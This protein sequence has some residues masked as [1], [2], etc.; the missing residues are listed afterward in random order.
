VIAVSGGGSGAMSTLLTEPGASGSVIE[1]LIPYSSS[2]MENFL[3]LVPEQACSERNAR[4]MAMAAYLR[5]VKLATSDCNRSI[6]G[7]ACTAALVT[8]RPRRGLH[9]IHVALQTEKM[10]R[11]LSLNLKKGARTREQEEALASDLII[12]AM[13]DLCEISFREALATYPEEQLLQESIV[14]DDAVHELFVGTSEL[15]PLTTSR[16]ATKP[17]TI[18]PGAFNPLHDG[19]RSIASIASRLTG[20]SC[21][22]ELSI[23]NVDKLPLDYL[24][25]DHRSKRI[26]SE[27]PLVL[28]RAPTFIEKSV[29]FPGA[30]FAVGVDTISRI[31]DSRYYNNDP[32]LATRALKSIRDQSCS[33]LVFGRKTQD[34]FLGLDDLVLPD[35]LEEICTGVPEQEF[36]IDISSTELRNKF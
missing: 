28:T 20:Q 12:H 1:A 22:L 2:A 6:A 21:H 7:L 36:R 17:L 35:I 29:L 27:F 3:G 25:I 34:R 15:L 11:S 18:F 10:T 31:A 14:G 24:E 30:T 13:A 23:T 33:F 26:V 9:Q 5:A 16:G 4:A 19:H 32:D 8:N